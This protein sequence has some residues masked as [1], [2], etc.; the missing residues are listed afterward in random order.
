[1]ELMVVAGRPMHKQADVHVRRA[2]LQHG[3]AGG[4]MATIFI[5]MFVKN[6]KTF[7]P[8]RGVEKER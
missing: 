7:L 2:T 8:I 3:W 6:K 5:L 4:L 1:M